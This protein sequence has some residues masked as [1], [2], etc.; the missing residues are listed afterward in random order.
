MTTQ[1]TQP[2][3][4]ATERLAEL[5]SEREAL[6]ERRDAAQSWRDEARKV[7]NRSDERSAIGDMVSCDSELSRIH[8]EISEVL[9]GSGLRFV[10]EETYDGPGQNGASSQSEVAAE[11]LHRRISDWVRSEGCA[12]IY[13][14]LIAD[15]ALGAAAAEAERTVLWEATTFS[16][17]TPA[18]FQSPTLTLRVTRGD[19]QPVMCAWK[20]FLHCECGSRVTQSAPKGENGDETCA[21]HITCD[22]TGEVVRAVLL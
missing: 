10:L 3:G 22:R 11:V 18:E 19:G 12:P 13:A 15:K 17:G 1:T 21:R 20:D 16:E 2:T 9:P 14:N 7:S 4:R 5:R 6:I 8:Q